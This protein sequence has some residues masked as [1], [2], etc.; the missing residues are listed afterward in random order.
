MTLPTIGPSP[1]PWGPWHVAQYVPNSVLPLRIDSGMVATGL[2]NRI[3]ARIRAPMRADPGGSIP[4]VGTLRAAGGR[5]AV[6]ASSSGCQYMS[7]F[8]GSA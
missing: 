4:S 2:R 7:S 8:Q 1:R 5:A 6:P 3:P